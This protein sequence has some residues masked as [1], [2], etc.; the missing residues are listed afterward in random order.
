MRRLIGMGLALA[1]L[2]CGGSDGG[3]KGA[4]GDTPVRYVICSQGEANCFVAARFKSL[5]SCQS[6]KDWSEMLCD[7]KST[8][9]AMVCRKDPG[10][11]ISFA[12]CVP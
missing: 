10:P 2:G 6:H 4:K 1:L 8:P 7:S 11:T 3:V 5:D 9:G 12:Y